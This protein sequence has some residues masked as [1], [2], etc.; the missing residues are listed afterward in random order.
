MG[1]KTNIS[2]TSRTWNPWIACQKV[3][4]GCANCYMFREMERYGLD[5]T[6]VTKTKTWNQPKRWQK[7]CAANNTKE[8]V[9]T[10]SWSD[11]FIKQA[12]EWRPDAWKI[13]KDCP[14]LIWQILTKRPELIRD[15]LPPDWGN[16]YDNVALG[17]SVESNKYL[18][19][20]DKLIKIPSKV[21]FISAE[22]LL[23][24]L[25]DLNLKD[26]E[27]LIAGGESGSSFRPMDIEWA[28][29]IRD[30][31]KKAKVPFF[32]K[33]GANFKPGQNNTIDGVTYEEW[34]K[35]WLN[36]ER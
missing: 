9:F 8:M 35:D 12:D 18:S 7:E 3:S 30:K 22:P 4:P 31:C 20:I 24:P 10:C 1:N 32:F 14:N 2:W 17:V 6:V 11:F 36:E 21:H 25:P 16:G 28:K 33:Q 34:P 26:V 23:G 15:R 19:R 5:P 27:W 13:I 29:E